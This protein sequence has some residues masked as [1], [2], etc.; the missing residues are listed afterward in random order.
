MAKRGFL[1][2]ALLAAA[3]IATASIYLV[4]VAHPVSLLLRLHAAVGDETLV[5]DEARYV[6]PGG[7]G[8]FKIRD[9]QFFLSNIALVAGSTQYLEPD[10]YHLVRF[11][12]D[13]G[14]YEL[15]LPELPREDYLRL[16][17]GI[18]VDAA[19]NGSIE[20]VGDLDPNGRMAWSWDVGYKFVLVEGGL[21]IDDTQ[22]P[23]VYHVGFDENYVPLSI[24]L[25]ETLFEQR[26]PVL[27][28]RVDLLRMF[29]GKQTVDMTVLSNVKFDRNDA[30]LL[31]NNYADMVSVCAA[32]C[33]PDQVAMGP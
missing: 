1:L 28:L 11:D 29:A 16:E 8:S 26:N 4:R 20:S 17:F 31:A 19:A 7:P 32:D 10:S 9:F 2:S 14:V 6:N 5:L 3:L 24:E 27:D 12:D 18:G 30:R 15:V 22:Y 25:D 13:D 21:V 23:L 33:S